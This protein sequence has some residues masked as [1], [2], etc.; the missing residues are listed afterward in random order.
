MIKV[1]DKLNLNSTIRDVEKYK[2]KGKDLGKEIAYYYKTE[3]VLKLYKECKSLPNI[4]GDDFS[5]KTLT[6]VNNIIKEAE[7]TKYL[8]AADENGKELPLFGLTDSEISVYY[9][10]LTLSSKDKLL[11]KKKIIDYMQQ[12]KDYIDPDNEN[13][14]KIKQ[15]F[16]LDICLDNNIN[17][18][19]HI[20]T[21]LTEVEMSKQLLDDIQKYLQ[22]LVIC[23]EK[24]DR[25]AE[26]QVA[27]K[28]LEIENISE[29]A[30]IFMAKIEK[31]IISE[32]PN[33]LLIMDSYKRNLEEEIEEDKLKLHKLN[34]LLKTYEKLVKDEE[35]KHLLDRYLKLMCKIDLTKSV[36]STM[37]VVKED[38]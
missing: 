7:V 18:S 16:P 11:L 24:C 34:L 23:K 21:Y 32:A 8:K 2:T 3:Y 30:K 14:T 33:T 35:Y 10:D 19:K 1:A 20:E 13:L 12:S 22:K 17:F 28:S 38:V 6:N 36:I 29:K 15:M 26:K 5:E 4:K 25:S 31:A 37:V 9:G 27:T